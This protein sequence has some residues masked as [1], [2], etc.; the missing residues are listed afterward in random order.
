MRWINSTLSKF[1]CLAD[2]LI[3][4]HSF[5]IVIKLITNIRI[6]IIKLYLC[7]VCKE[8]AGGVDPFTP[9]LIIIIQI[10]MLGV[11]IDYS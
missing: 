4:R 10:V 7:Y 6:V 2:F 11:I 5:V 1:E 8:S 3:K 9:E